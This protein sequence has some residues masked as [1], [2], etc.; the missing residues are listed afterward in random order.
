[1][2]QVKLANSVELKLI[3]GVAP[4]EESI[5]NPPVTEVTVPALLSVVPQEKELLAAV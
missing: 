1:M 5:P 3:E 2:P 4:S